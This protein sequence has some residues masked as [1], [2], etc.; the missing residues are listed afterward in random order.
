MGVA[1]KG[2]RNLRSGCGIEGM[3][4][5]GEENWECFGIAKRNQFG[6][7]GGDGGVVVARTT[8]E[9]WPAPAQT[10]K[11]HGMTAHVELSGLVHEQRDA[12]SFYFG[13][14]RF[15]PLEQVVIAFDHVNA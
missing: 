14:K 15:A 5:M 3:G 1:G 10:E 6:K 13:F 2:K 4:M 7:G 12:R 8:T 9:R 11:L